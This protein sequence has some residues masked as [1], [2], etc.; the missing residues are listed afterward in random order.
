MMSYEF[1]NSLDELHNFV[2]QSPSMLLY[3]LASSRQTVRAYLEEEPPPKSK[4]IKKTAVRVYVLDASGSMHGPRA[5]FRDAILIAELNALR[6]KAQQSV[7]YDPLYFSFFNDSP[8]ELARIDNGPEATRQIEKLFR[9]SPAEGQTDI[10]LALMSSFESIRA[11]Q[12]KDPY[13]SRA[14]VVL[15][16]DGEDAVDLE[17]IRKTRKP[18][19]GLD[20][21]LSFISLGEENTDLRSLVLD[22]RANGGRAFYH[23]LADAEIGIARTEFDSTWRTLLPGDVTASAGA[24]EALLPHLEA[25][26]QIAGGRPTVVPMRA[27]GQFDAMFP[28]PGDAAGHENP[29]S[30]RLADI[31]DAVGEAAS[32]ASADSRG[33]ESV[34][35]LQHLLGLY[36]IPVPKYLA[37]AQA[38]TPQIKAA[39]ER[40]R[41]LCKPFG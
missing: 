12:G 1:T 4:R 26:E 22:Q 28:A 3:D 41:L 38:P 34:T 32:L 30:Q 33:S 20:I 10:S 2:I 35:L 14:T 36:G 11:A 27:D 7:P 25:L 29:V 31:L 6:V 5:R 9:H 17:L 39:L 16:T 23:H 8:T 24:L 40:V 13:L 15:V 18:F 37:V 21:S 19:E